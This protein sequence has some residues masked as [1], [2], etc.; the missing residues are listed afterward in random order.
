MSEKR[1]LAKGALGTFESAVMGIAGTAPAF[2]VA[3]TTA[4]IV[5]SVGVLSVG[6]ILYC[7]LVMFGI[8]LA[9]VHLS[10]ITPHAGAAYAWVG[11]VFG[12]KWGFF[13][14][15]GLL[16][17]SVFFMVSATIPAATSTLV[18]IAPNLVESTTWVT[19]TAAIWLTLVT[20]VVTKGIK[21]ASYAQL[22]LTGIETAVIFA[23]IIGAFIQYG[24]KPAHTPSFIWF[25]P[26]S[27]TPQLFA[28]GALTAIF[29]YW[30]WDVT[31]NLSEETKAGKGDDH[32]PASK[33]AFWA[34]VNLILF[35]IIMMIVVLIVL[36]D[37]E[38]AK[39]NTNVLY[40]IASK[41]FPTPWNYL[42]VLSTILST[43]GTIETQI[44]QFSRSMFAMAR[45]EMLHP[46]Y[47]KIHPEWKTPWMATLVIWF[48]GVLLLFG[49]SYMPSVK[50]IL[51]SSILAI[52]FQICFYMSLAGFA[53]AWHYRNKLKR[54]IYSAISYVLWP[55]FAALFM[56]F[57]ALY[58]IPTFDKVTNIIGIGGILLGFVPLFLDRFRRVRHKGA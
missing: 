15:W 3:V 50:S 40:A 51:D 29:F 12:E 43:I 28:T 56:V 38:I 23:L 42:A 21:H 47:A 54:G 39:A 18:L 20:L 30:G 53:C 5:A 10:K 49:S 36:T 41:L 22:I 58:S 9:F 34:M 11:H 55:L 57:I 4:A 2:S 8:M 44:L 1:G 6:S 46:R 17:A 24:G 19:F 33:G 26:F 27:F 37:D 25:S 48:L 16:V 14:G 52:G 45:D 13:T 32:H 35:F 31:M 7:G